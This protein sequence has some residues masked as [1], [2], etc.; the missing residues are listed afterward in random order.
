MEDEFKVD[1]FSDQPL[2]KD[3]AA[4]LKNI[5]LAKTEFE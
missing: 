1:A 3:K 4:E 2:N 5:N